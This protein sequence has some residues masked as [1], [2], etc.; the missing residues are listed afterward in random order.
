ME[1]R[2]GRE[3]EACSV[4]RLTKLLEATLESLGLGVGRAVRDVTA[5]KDDGEVGRW[6]KRR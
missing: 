3:Y 6:R 4:L 1:L 5:E 2:A